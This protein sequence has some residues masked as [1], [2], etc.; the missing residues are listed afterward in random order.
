MSDNSARNKFLMIIPLLSYLFVW[1]LSIIVF[2][3]FTA[4]SD[5][6]G[7]SLI[8]MIF[9]LPMTTFVI[10]AIIGINNLCGNFKWLFPIAFGIMYML[11]EYST[12]SA[13]N[14]V[15]FGK[16]NLPS[17]EMILYGGIVSLIGLGIGILIRYI[18]RK[19]DRFS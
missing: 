4:P 19:K 9:L 12:F 16:L 17:F 14:I 18:K 10:S 2:W 13:K 11:C 15:T 8:F 5:A 6:L 1:V 7:Y 3:F